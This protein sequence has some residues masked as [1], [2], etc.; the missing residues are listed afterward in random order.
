MVLLPGGQLERRVRFREDGGS[1]S[2]EFVRSGTFRLTIRGLEIDMG[3]WTPP[4]R[5]LAGVLVLEY[6][7]PLD[8]PNI[9]E[10]YRRTET[11]AD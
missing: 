9:V 5:F 3:G 4:A 2:A 6:G 1:L 8:G 11:V 7:D 10:T